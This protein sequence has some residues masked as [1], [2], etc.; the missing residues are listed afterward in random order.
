MM[1][2][3]IMVLAHGLVVKFREYFDKVVKALENIDIASNVYIEIFATSPRIA[4]AIGEK[5]FFR[6]ENYLATT[7]LL[8]ENGDTT[9]VKIITAGG[10][11]GLLDLFDWGSARDYAYIIADELSKALGKKY[12]VI[13]NIDYLDKSK[14]SLMHNIN[15]R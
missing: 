2:G 4:L 14:S 10:R 1:S 7:T 11:R 6:A 9:I 15:I 8:I 3:D 12:E 5:Y 13:M